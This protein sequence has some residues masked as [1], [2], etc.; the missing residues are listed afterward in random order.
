MPTL[1]EIRRSFPQ[2]DDLT[3]EAL[4]NA[5]H[6]KFYSDMPR[7]E[8]N[9]RIGLDPYR[10]EAEQRLRELKAKGIDTRPGY[11]RRVLQGMTLGAAD[12]ILA[13][14]QTPL[15]MIRRRTAN[16]I[17]AYR[18]AKAF[19][20]VS[21]DEARRQ[22]GL[23]GHAAEIAGSVGSGLGLA[24]AGITLVAKSAGAL[25]RLFGLAGE[26]AAYGG[27]SGFFEGGNSLSD[28][29]RGAG[30]GAAMGGLAGAAV[31]VAAAGLGTVAAPVISNLRA[32]MNPAGAAA[33]QVARALADS[34]RTV[35]DVAADVAA[36]ARAGQPEYTIA[37]AL[38]NPGQR[39]LSTV[40]RSPGPG[41]TMAVEFLE[42]RQA[43]Q[44]R[45]IID[46][47]AEGLQA[48][49]T[50][51]QTKAALEAER[52][53]AAAANYGLARQQAGAVN[54]TPA[55]KIADD[56]LEPGVNK[57]V[58]PG[59]QIADNS[60]EAAVRRARSYLTD[61]RSMVVS[62][63]QAFAA[64]LEIDH[65]I[66]AGTPAQQRVL[67]QIRNALDD[68]LAASSPSYAKARDLYRQQSKIIDAIEPGQ[69]AAQR[70]RFENILEQF[71]KLSEEERAAYRVGFADKL[72]EKIQRK[73]STANSAREAETLLPLL[74]EIAPA[75]NI[76]QLVEKIGREKR[77]FQTRAEAIGG[78]KTAENLADMEAMKVDPAVVAALLR[79]DTR[80]L[81][82][83]ALST[84]TNVLHGSTPQVREHVA[85]LLLQHGPSPTIERDI[86]KQMHGLAKQRL[87]LDVLMRGTTIGTATQ[88]PH[89]TR[90]R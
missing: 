34:G 46:A 72:I 36:A 69:I 18:H 20:D 2:Y 22:Q 35:G 81:T 16:P 39:L 60:V 59:S 10:A 78:S 65:L 67:I 70:G 73:A 9:R 55:I 79:G 43:G 49:A 86:A 19:E 64:K 54:V 12:E 74:R 71:R 61:G 37:D 66:D 41:R 24:R 50:A 47:L 63:P 58:N 5:L 80:S 90:A 38:G 40:A 62:H 76:G 31:P 23:L 32:R 7:E 14:L 83:K 3:D 28:R 33:S 42:T 75:N 13:G 4:A 11:G 56:F 26:G 77:M 44:G 1:A 8:F 51:A 82:T 21:L 17:E 53:A 45:R 6:A 30:A 27:V 84:A 29:M 52:K 68:Q 15:E 48:P 87:L 88:M 85:R 25:G 57:I 89:Q